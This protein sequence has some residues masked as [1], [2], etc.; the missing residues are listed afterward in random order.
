MGNASK[1]YRPNRKVYKLRFEDEDMDGLVVRVRST[2]VGS[3]LVVAG[4]I[5]IDPDNLGPQ[6]LAKLHELFAMLA[7]AL[8]EWNV[9]DD[10]GVPVPA[11]L[12]GIK[13]QD[14][15][16]V[17]VIVRAWFEAISGVPAPLG[18]PSSGGGPSLAPS[19]PMEPLSASQGS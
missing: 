10:D 6:D 13:S 5:T 2:S 8:V 17:M 3:L 16:F 1:G 4:F 7:S 19:I 11:T 14:A 18:P 9:E 15:D 12:D